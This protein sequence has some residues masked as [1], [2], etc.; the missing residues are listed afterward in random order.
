MDCKGRSGEYLG[1][2]CKNLDRD[3]SGDSEKWSNSGCMLKVELVGF[4]D[5]SLHEEVRKRR[6]GDDTKAFGLRS[7]K[8]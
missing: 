1:G 5:G 4:S 3:D 2:Y 6:A 8:N 7:W